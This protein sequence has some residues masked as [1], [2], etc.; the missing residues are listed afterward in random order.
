MV[1][2]GTRDLHCF[3]ARTTLV[4]HML[5]EGGRIISCCLDSSFPRPSW[6]LIIDWPGVR[7][8]RAIRHTYILKSLFGGHHRY[9]ESMCAQRGG[10]DAAKRALIDY[11]LSRFSNFFLSDLASQKN[12]HPTEKEGRK[13]GWIEGRKE[14]R[15]R[16]Y[17]KFSLRMWKNYS[18]KGELSIQGRFSAADK[19]PIRANTIWQGTKE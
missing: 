17:F 13:V 3:S 19:A 1:F 2:K 16:N 6:R 18:L 8:G 5:V 10:R 14:R 7:K 12:R 9:P 4:S 15:R 11:P